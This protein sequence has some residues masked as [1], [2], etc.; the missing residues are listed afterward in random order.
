M[1]TTTLIVAVTFGGF[2]LLFANCNQANAQARAVEPAQTARPQGIDAKAKV[3][4]ENVIGGINFPATNR[5]WLRLTGTA[6]VLSANTFILADGT[7]ISL[8]MGMDA[9]DLEQQGVIRGTFYPAGKE[10]AEFLRKLIGEQPVTCLVNREDR[11]RKPVRAHCYVGE[12]S[13]EAEMVRSGWAVSDHSLLDAFEIMARE[14]KR[15]LWRGQFI[16]PRRWRKG[17]RL[18]GE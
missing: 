13:L 6:R 7:E 16:A 11:N 5:T 9:P 3:I 14:N 18:P 2:A 1:K 8:S 17:E 10:A 15:G 4:K 12:M